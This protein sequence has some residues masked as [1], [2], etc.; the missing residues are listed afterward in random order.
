M[1]I[2]EMGERA[3]RCKSRSPPGDR[4]LSSRINLDKHQ[5]AL[6]ESSYAEATPSPEN[7]KAIPKNGLTD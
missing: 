4:R 1:L 5:G 7:K 6:M 2:P 3:C